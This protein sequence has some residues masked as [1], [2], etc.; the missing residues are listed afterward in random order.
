MKNER[1]RKK[2]ENIYVH[3]I[4]CFEFLLLCDIGL[5]RFLIFFECGWGDKKLVRIVV[6]KVCNRFWDHLWKFIFNV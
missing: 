1:K 3:G 2:A 6:C 4:V 5:S